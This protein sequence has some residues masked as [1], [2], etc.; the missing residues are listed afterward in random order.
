MVT[1]YNHQTLPSPY[2]IHPLILHETFNA[3]FL[4]DVNVSRWALLP[5]TFWTLKWLLI[6][7]SQTDNGP[8]LINVKTLACIEVDPTNELPIL[9]DPGRIFLVSCNS[10]SCCNSTGDPAEQH[11]LL[12]QCPKMQESWSIRTKHAE[13]EGGHYQ[14]SITFHHLFKYGHK[15]IRLGQDL[16]ASGSQPNYISWTDPYPVSDPIA[17][18][19]SESVHA[20]LK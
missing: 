19:G 12:I 7:S 17:L 1:S 9:K 5:I 16:A 3:P 14:F 20:Q 18:M 4:S 11:I 8:S 2:V 15:W 6:S 13:R 10:S